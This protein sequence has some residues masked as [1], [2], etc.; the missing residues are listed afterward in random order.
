MAHGPTLQG[1][2]GGTESF[3]TLGEIRT[4]LHERDSDWQ[5]PANATPAEAAEHSRLQLIRSRLRLT[6]QRA[7]F[8]LFGLRNSMRLVLLRTIHRGGAWCSFPFYSGQLSGIIRWDGWRPLFNGILPADLLGIR[9]L[10]LGAAALMPWCPVS[11]GVS[12]LG[13]PV[14]LWVL[15]EE[16]QPSSE[17]RRSPGRCILRRR[18]PDIDR[19]TQDFWLCGN[20]YGAH[21]SAPIRRIYLSSCLRLLGDWQFHIAFSAWLMTL[22]WDSLAVNQDFS[23]REPLQLPV[24]A[25]RSLQWIS[26]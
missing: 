24:D 12:Y 21:V 10:W 18:L 20:L 6:W 3:Q 9:D 1:L 2:G 11:H 26:G 14:P 22:E 8:V 17:D 16:D 4:F 25:H 13:F 15:L 7:C 23:K 5:A 19:F